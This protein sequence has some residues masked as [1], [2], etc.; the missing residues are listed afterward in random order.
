MAPPSH[1]RD[2]DASNGR[3]SVVGASI[4]GLFAARE[5]ARSGL[6]V[7]VWEALSG[8]E[9]GARTLIVTPTWLGMLD[10]DPEP[11][12]LNHIQAF[13]LISRRES[14]CIPLHEPDLVLERTRF[15]DLLSSKVLA[16]G[17]EVVFHRR[18]SA[19]DRNG[20]GCLLH[21][22]NGEGGE[23]HESSY[24][25]GADGVRSAVGR[26]VGRD[27]LRS[28]AIVQARVPLPADY[29]QHTAR[30]WLD[31]TSTRFFYWL[32]PESSQEGVAGLIAENRRDAEKA[33]DRFLGAHGL[34]ALEYQAADVPVQRAGVRSRW[35]GRNGRVLLTGDAAG[36]VKV[37]T[38]GG[39]VTGMRGGW[40]AARSLTLGT[41]Y[42]D[43]LRSLQQ[44]LSAHAMLRY[45]LDRFTDEDYDDLLRQLNRRGLRLLGD[46]SR[47][48]MARVLWRLLLAQPRWLSLAA[49][50][51]V[52]DNVPAG[53]EPMPV[54]RGPR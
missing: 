38:V 20:R 40:A 7:K 5:M 48:G 6:R 32:I 25:L 35:E 4:A 9:H 21:F 22:S 28:V 30:V 34:A 1:Q 27:S 47:D 17:G 53:A 44:E 24:V 8:L 45:V 12:I 36:H 10:F 31:R 2:S 42:R 49:R 43:E 15:L 14:V 33:L 23:P 19:L 39:V 50:A 26:A 51:L 29:P 52:R 11:A 54:S 3:V 37:T 16:A 41:S 13:E 18:L 46:Q